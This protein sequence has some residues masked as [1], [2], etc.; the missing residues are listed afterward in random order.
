MSTEKSW[1]SKL[2]VWAL[3][4]LVVF[5]PVSAWLVSASGTYQLSLGRDSVLFLLL[6]LSLSNVRSWRR[7]DLITLLS[8][9]FC[10]LTLATFFHRQDSL[11]QWLRGVRYYA[12]PFLLL[13][14]LRLSPLDDKQRS[15]LSWAFLGAYLVVLVG[16]TIDFIRPEWLRLTFDATAR[17]YLGIYHKAG[18]LSRLQSLLA[19]PNALGLFLMVAL[20]M[21]PIWASRLKKWLSVLLILIGLIALVLTF[22]RSS[23]IGLVAGLVFIVGFGYGRVGPTVYR[24]VMVAMVSLLLVGVVAIVAKPE[25]LTRFRSN[26]LRLEQYQRVWNE[27]AEI[28][29]WGRGAG[30][31]G[32]VSEYRLD[33]G[34]SYF[35]ENTYLDV[36]ENLGVLPALSY[37]SVFILLIALLLKKRTEMG[38]ALA[39]ACFGLMVAGL[40]IDSFTGQAALWSVLIFAAVT[41]DRPAAS[42]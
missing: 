15:R 24:W 23:Y 11:S 22:S 30:A 42:S 19:G 35:T 41:I 38:L 8:A 3:A 36:Y 10:L 6:I 32:L 40:F 18:T 16:A 37:L 5:L 39:A 21:L 12:E 4:V 14:L 17:G 1:A 29:F 33:N 25:Y 20:L 27:R 13:A 26:E 2:W 31:A 9:L 34:P 28:G 7:P